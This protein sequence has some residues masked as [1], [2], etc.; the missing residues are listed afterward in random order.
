MTRR[1]LSVYSFISGLCQAFVILENI[2]FILFVYFIFRGCSYQNASAFQVNLHANRRHAERT[3]S[4]EI[5]ARKYS[6]ASLLRIHMKTAHA[7]VR[8]HTPPVAVH[9]G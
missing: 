8:N 5:C 4:C 6:N 7:T 9:Q 3:V 2:V 1:N